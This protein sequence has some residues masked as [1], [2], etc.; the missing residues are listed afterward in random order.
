MVKLYNEPMKCEIFRDE[1]WQCVCLRVSDVCE[2]SRKS[3]S[4]RFNLVKTLGVR[5]RLT[6]TP[7]KTRVSTQIKEMS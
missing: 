4:A 2:Q 6:I 3:E 1:I 5:S 7:L